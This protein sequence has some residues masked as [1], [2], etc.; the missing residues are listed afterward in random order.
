MKKLFYLLIMT[1]VLVLGVYLKPE[2]TL[3]FEEAANVYKTVNHVDLSDCDWLTCI[4]RDEVN[5]VAYYIIN[6]REN[7]LNIDDTVY[8][9]GDM[10]CTVVSLDSNGFYLKTSDKVEQGFSGLPITSITG[11]KV[12]YVSKLMLDKTV[13][14]IWN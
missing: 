5:D 6:S 14:C 8:I 3:V 7:V 1:V 13:Y 9:N 11:D 4:Y 12:G 2:P 10:K